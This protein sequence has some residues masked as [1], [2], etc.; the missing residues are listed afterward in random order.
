MMMMMMMMMMMTTMTT[1]AL[2]SV[3]RVRCHVEVSFVKPQF[4]DQIF[5]RL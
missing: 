5:V 2:E 3:P 1:I 4:V